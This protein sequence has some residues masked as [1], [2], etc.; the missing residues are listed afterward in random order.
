MN[1]TDYHAILRTA[2]TRLGTIGK[3]REELESESAKL[4]QFIMATI[5][6]LPDAEREVFVKAF[7][8]LKAVVK[9]KEVGLKEACLK[10]LRE[11]AP[12]YLTAAKVRDRVVSG[13]FDF[14]GY[15]TNPLASISTTL[16]RFKSEEVEE[17]TIEG[18]TAFRA[19]GIKTR[20]PRF[21]STSIVSLPR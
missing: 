11:A 20:T 3:Q 1:D 10:V 19:V 14:S 9:E 8:E 16:R 21:A 7:D 6:M 5:N 12:E 18:V 15:T 2:M 17:T 4:G 13:G